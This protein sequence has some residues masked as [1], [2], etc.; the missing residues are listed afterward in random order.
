[1]SELVAVR[2]GG[3]LCYYR[4]GSSAGSGEQETQKMDSLRL[5]GSSPN[6]F[7]THCHHSVNLHVIMLLV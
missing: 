6:P 7:M 1:M 5:G 2:R 3:L 4:G